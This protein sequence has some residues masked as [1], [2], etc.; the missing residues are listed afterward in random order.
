[1]S[2]DDVLTF[3]EALV[4]LRVGRSTL[5]RAVARNRVPHRRIGRVLR[6]SRAALLA[7][8]GS[9]LTTSPEAR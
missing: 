8:L 4:L 7:W 5:Y 2:A 9:S 3:D 6:F 1:V